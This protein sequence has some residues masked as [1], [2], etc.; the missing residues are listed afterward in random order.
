MSDTYGVSPSPDQNLGNSEVLGLGDVFEPTQ[1]APTFID[2][3]ATDPGY[4]PAQPS[5]DQSYGQASGYDPTYGQP[6]PQPY[7]PASPQP[8][9]GYADYSVYDPN[10]YPGQAQFAPQPQYA[11]QPYV[12]PT[13]GFGTLVPGQVVQTAYG[14]FTVGPKSKLAAGLLG[15]F[16][17]SVGVGQF[18]RGN[19]G[20]GVLQI[21]VTIVS[22]GVGA[23]WGLIEG[24]VVLA[25]QPGSPSSL[26]SN[27]QIMG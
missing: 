10:Q 11:V 14:T 5:Y 6:Q 15:I 20:M 18:Y 23:L 9:A 1:P 7:P 26:D 4:T 22:C 21:V 17:G 8:M 16:L 3:F 27:G 24:I 12:Q 2:P 25:S 13:H 19:I